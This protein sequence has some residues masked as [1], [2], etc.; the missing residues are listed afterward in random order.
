[1]TRTFISL[2]RSSTPFSA[3]SAFSAHSAVKHHGAPDRRLTL[4]FPLAEAADSTRDAPPRP[5]PPLRP[6]P[7]QH[8]VPA[9]VL[10]VE[11]GGVALQ[12]LL[13][14]QVAGQQRGP[15]RRILRQGRSLRPLDRGD[16]GAV[17]EE[18]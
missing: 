5:P 16:H 11:G 1:M 6:E 9:P 4:A 17:V 7:D 12:V 10:H 13:A 15:L 14:Q 8:H 3:P 2:T 18:Y